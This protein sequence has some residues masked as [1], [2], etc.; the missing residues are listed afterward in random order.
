VREDYPQFEA[1]T[2]LLGRV[3]ALYS[4]YKQARHLFDFDDLLVQLVVLL[5][6]SPETARRFSSVTGTSWWTSTRTPTPCR[7]APPICSS[8][9]A[10]T[11][12]GRRRCPEP[13]TPSAAPCYGGTSSRFRKTFCDAELVTIEQN[14]RS[15][16]GVLD[17][18]H[19]LMEQMKKSF[20]KR[21]SH[22]GRASP[23]R[24]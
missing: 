10:A 2:D 22:N 8:V 18:A 12:C 20:R 1:E 3:A 15:N 6:K 14:Y 17:V 9:E 11:S 7:P 13:S 19:G 4:E 24:C 5:E 23:S 16:Q 21:L